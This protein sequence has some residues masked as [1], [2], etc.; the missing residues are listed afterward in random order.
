MDCQIKFKPRVW[1]DQDLEAVESWKKIISYK[2]KSS[3]KPKCKKC[4]V[5]RKCRRCILKY[6]T[7][8]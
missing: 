7:S 8:K 3:S 5:D 6:I 2:P 1:F 4:K